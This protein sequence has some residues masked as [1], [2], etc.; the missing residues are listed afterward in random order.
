M[1]AMNLTFPLSFFFFGH[2]HDT[3]KFLGQGLNLCHEW[4]HQI[5]SPPGNTNDQPFLYLPLYCLK[6]F[7]N[8]VL[9]YNFFKI[10]KC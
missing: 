10:E 2:D 3:R 9:S 4:Q 5:H 7:N 8:H 1:K 6:H